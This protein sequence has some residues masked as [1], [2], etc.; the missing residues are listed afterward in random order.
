M[1]RL[2]ELRELRNLTQGDLAKELKVSQSTIAMWESGKRDPDTEAL[3]RIADYF[4]VSTDYLIGRSN[5]P[6]PGE[7]AATHIDGDKS[8]DDLTPEMLQQIE[9]FK[10]FII[11]EHKKKT[12]SSPEKSTDNKS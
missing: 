5:S 4:G 8:Y 2:R 3:H 6:H 1:K 9:A 11:E 12:G 7:I 10:R